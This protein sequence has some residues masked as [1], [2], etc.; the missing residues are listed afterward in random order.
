[1]LKKFIGLATVA[2]MLFSLAACKPPKKENPMGNSIA[3]EEVAFGGNFVGLNETEKFSVIIRSQQELMDFFDNRNVNWQAAPIWEN[4]DGEFFENEVLVLVFF[5]T[6][7]SNIERAI[8]NVYV[9]G[10]TLTLQLIWRYYSDAVTDDELFSFYILSV[11]KTEVIDVNEIK[12]DI[13]HKTM[14]K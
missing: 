12:T 3:F 13:E 9:D 4:H 8:D 14:Y 11:S 5:W 6:S 7:G 2:L 1:M 10:E